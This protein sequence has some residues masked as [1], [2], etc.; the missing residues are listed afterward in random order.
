[1]G[2][3]NGRESSLVSWMSSCHC[4]KTKHS[5][6]TQEVTRRVRLGNRFRKVFFHTVLHQIMN[7][8]RRRASLHLEGK[9]KPMTMMSSAFWLHFYLLENCRIEIQEPF[10]WFESSKHK[11]YDPPVC[12]CM[13]ASILDTARVQCMCMFSSLLRMQ[14]GGGEVEGDGWA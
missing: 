6:N 3:L 11:K 14:A 2:C 8:T 7:E 12:V 13:H 5:H 10:I 9:T 1:M 4:L